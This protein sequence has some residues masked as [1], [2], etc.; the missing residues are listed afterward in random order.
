LYEFELPPGVSEFTVVHGL[1][2]NFA[3]TTETTLAATAQSLSAGVA[4]STVIA[5]GVVVLAALFYISRTTGHRWIN[6]LRRQESPAPELKPVA[7]SV[8]GG[9]GGVIRSIGDN[10]AER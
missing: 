7:E 3:A 8:V 10:R 2:V 5:A 4:R 6:L 9:Q 1:N